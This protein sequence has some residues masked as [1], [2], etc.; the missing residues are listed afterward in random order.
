MQ[1]NPSSANRSTFI[2]RRK[3]A[4][5]APVIP[6]A[7]LLP[8]LIIALTLISVPPVSAVCGGS[9]NVANETELNSA[10]VAFNGETGPC[11]FTISFTADITLTGD[12]QEITNGDSTVQL[13][14]MGTGRTLNG[15]DAGKTLYV[16]NAAGTRL[17]VDNL[18][19]SGSTENGIYTRLP[20]TVTG[21]II[22]DNR[23]SGLTKN[24]TTAVIERST[25]NAN[26]YR[27]IDHQ[28]SGTMTVVS[29]TLSHNSDDGIS[30]T[31]FLTM[32]NSTI[33]GNGDHGLS[34]NNGGTAMITNVTIDNNGSI[35]VRNAT[36]SELTLQ[37]SIAANSG[38]SDCKNI[39]STVDIDFT[40]IEDTGGNACGASDT[41]DGNIIG[42]EAL[43]GPLQNNG[44]STATHALLDLSGDVTAASPAIDAGSDALAAGLTVDQRGS[45]RIINVVDMGAYEGSNN[46]V[47]PGFPITVSDEDALNEAIACYNALTLA[48]NYTINL[49]AA[50]NLTAASQFI[51]NPV[52]GISL[53]LDGH[54]FPIDGQ[55]LPGV[56]PLQIFAESDVSLQNITIS[57]GQTTNRGAGIFNSGT[58]TMSHS[59][60]SNNHSNGSE[61]AGGLYNEGSA[62]I[63]FSTFEANHS[64]GSEFAGGGISTVKESSLTVT[65]SAFINNSARD[66]GGVAISDT[67]RP[68]TISNSTFSGN[69]AENLG[70]GLINERSILILN[71]NTIANNEAG[72]NGGGITTFYGGCFTADVQVLLASGT[73][74]RIADGPGTP[75]D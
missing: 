20:I 73:S 28:G 24:G 43:L 15:N 32:T 14:I 38:D 25:F 11:L 17:T 51:N 52:A 42:H 44:G 22:Q 30:N 5:R 54:D 64:N 7:F 63:A 21:S 61:S 41:V 48:G 26:G 74:K 16:H 6:L 71:N 39:A 46:I 68:I 35:G 4:W 31:A 65:H 55:N 34:N 12:L 67:G 18:I 59:T 3:G 50:I 49:G 8:L 62:A 69:F 66:G 33:S 60:V 36:N 40:L 70:G 47:C 2:P 58:L 10:I 75:G 27:G 1:L 13:L 57:G 37:N 29:S 19:I 72:E 56:R 53:L 23:Q 45:P 9:T